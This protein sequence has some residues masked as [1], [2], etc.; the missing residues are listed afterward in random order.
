[1]Q[2]KTR[3]I[4]LYSNAYGDVYS[5]TQ[6]YTEE[7]GRIPYLTA[8][9][10][11]KKTKVSRAL[12]HAL[13][14]LDLEVDHRNLR[15]IQR[16]KEAKPH[17]SLNAL[18][19][20]PVKRAISIFIAELMNKLIGEVQPNKLLFEYLLQ[21]IQILELTEKSCANFH[22]AFMIGLSRFLGFYPDVS[23]YKDGLFFDLQSGTFVLDRPVHPHFLPPNESSVVANLLRMTY[24]NMATFRFS[25]H[26][27][28]I[29]IDHTLSYYRLHLTNFSDLKSVDIL[30]E[31]F[32]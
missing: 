27:R 10:K 12:F 16:I 15:E 7:F 2:E 25:R 18:L 11:G 23:T 8:K 13:A 31:I 3:G 4:V 17:I 1:M 6:I 9:A 30:H 21:S 14:V 5:I 26:E 22:L 19:N 32:S 24:G 20:D 28:R 29:I